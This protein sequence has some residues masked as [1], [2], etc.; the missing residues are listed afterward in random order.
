MGNRRITLSEIFFAF[1]KYY[2]VK[3][4]ISLYPSWEITAFF[5]AEEPVIDHI[6][7]QSGLYSY[8]NPFYA[9]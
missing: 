5:I 7:D 3:A 1:I 8:D 6:I 2:K 4:I 9:A